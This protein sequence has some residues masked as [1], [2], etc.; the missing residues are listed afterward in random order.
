ML[1]H[2]APYS[3]GYDPYDFWIFS[4]LKRA[5]KRTHFKSVESLIIKSTKLLKALQK[6][7]IQHV[8]TQWKIRMERCIKGEGKFIEREKF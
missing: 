3:P 6:Q 7:N 2:P 1:Q 8:F 4:E 5:L